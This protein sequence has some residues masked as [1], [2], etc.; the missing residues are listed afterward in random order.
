MNK[1]SQS[2]FAL[3]ALAGVL[4]AASLAIA[5]FMMSKDRQ[6]TW[7]PNIESKEKLERIKDALVQYQRAH[8][9]LPCPAPIN[10]LPDSINYGVEALNCA[11][12]PVISGLTRV[13]IGGGIFIRIGSLPIKALGLDS[14]FAID[15]WNNRISYVVME[16][17]TDPFQFSTTPG[18]L[19][20]ND[21]LGASIIPNGA[22][23]LISHGKD[24][25]GAVGLKTGLIGKACS[26]SSTRDQ[27]NCDNDK[28]FIRGDS[29]FEEGANYFDDI[30]EIGTVDAQATGINK[31]CMP[32]NPA[33]PYGWGT[34]CSGPYTNILHGASQTI[35]NTAAL[36]SGQADVVCNNGAFTLGANTCASAVVCN[37]A[38]TNWAG[39]VTGCTGNYATLNMGDSTSVANTAS[40]RTGNVTITCVGGTPVQSGAT[41]AAVNCNLPWGGTLA[42]GASITAYQTPSVSCGT[43]CTSETRT[44]NFGVLSGSYTNQNCSAP[45]CTNCNLPWGGTLAHN[46]SVTAFNTSS[47]PCGSS[48]QSEMRTCNDGTLSGTYAQQTCNVSPCATCNL[49]WGGSIGHGASVT[50]YAASNVT[51]GNTCDGQTRSCNNGTLSGTGDYSSCSVGSCATLVWDN[52]TWHCIS[53]DWN[54]P[55][56]VAFCPAPMQDVLYEYYVSQG[57]PKETCSTGGSQCYVDMPGAFGARFYY[58]YT[59]Q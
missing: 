12:V 33:S 59:C 30:I 8:H 52:I 35:V 19:E 4:I 40:G 5:T 24:G 15:N 29:V 28:Q 6:Q 16:Q 56:P 27:E 43:S 55:P 41:C 39:G 54:C 26:T 7:Q 25:G 49:P 21:T 18:L 3:L 2:G 32:P 9:K 51:C 48:C 31:P 37:G 57:T 44:C 36:L 13:D 1:T 45:A 38:S 11:A 42:H 34:G 17:L 46:S 20:L 58:T 14:D 23:A 53:G 10:Q 50:A 47:V 22:F